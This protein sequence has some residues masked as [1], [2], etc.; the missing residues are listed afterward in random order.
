M[1]N[2]LTRKLES[3][4][5]NTVLPQLYAYAL[6]RFNYPV[7]Q[8]T[9]SPNDLVN[10]AIRRVLY[11]ERVWEYKK[12]PDFVNFMK[13]VIRSIAGHAFKAVKAEKSR[14]EAVQQDSTSIQESAN[15]DDEISDIHREALKEIEN[16]LL[17]DEELLLM[18]YAMQEGNFSDKD[19]SSELSKDVIEIRN[20]K[21]RIRRRI[22]DIGER[23]GIK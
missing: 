17:E 20:M 9:M 18:F 14:H 15:T 21:K 7:L 22:A 13:T 16:C 2:E 10:E 11:G 5:W 12:H 6:A 1:D 3:V 4:D 19:L 8:N 23:L